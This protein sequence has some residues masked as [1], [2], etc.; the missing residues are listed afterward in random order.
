MSIKM[1][2]NVSEALDENL[3][4]QF[5]P[6][7]A[8]L[9]NPLKEQNEQLKAENAALKESLAQFQLLAE[10]NKAL[11]AQLDILREVMKGAKG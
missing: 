1:L 6:N 9:P 5:H 8:P 7:V 4:L 11:K 2:L 10:E 3:L